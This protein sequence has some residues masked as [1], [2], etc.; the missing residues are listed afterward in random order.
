MFNKVYLIF[1]YI[2]IQLF[3]KIE[4]KRDLSPFLPDTDSVPIAGYCLHVTKHPTVFIT[5]TRVDERITRASRVR[6][7]R[8]I[9]FDVDHE[10]RLLHLAELGSVNATTVTL[11][12]DK[13]PGDYSRFVYGRVSRPFLRRYVLVG[14]LLRVSSARFV[15]RSS[16][17]SPP[18][19]RASSWTFDRD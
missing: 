17:F 8:K 5:R 2:K 14:F 13:R 6:A 11:A 9:E 4:K 7:A 3:S 16:F 1:N 10:G 19:L 18:Y 15:S 12:A